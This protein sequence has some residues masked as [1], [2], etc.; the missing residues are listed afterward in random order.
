MYS[1]QYYLQFQA[2]AGGLGIQ[3]LQIRGDN[4]NLNKGMFP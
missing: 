3:S 2:A 4:Y 1:V